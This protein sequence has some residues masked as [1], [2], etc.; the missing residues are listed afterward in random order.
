MMWLP[1]R[2]NCSN[3][4][5]KVVDPTISGTTASVRL[6]PSNLSVNWPSSMPAK[7]LAMASLPSGKTLTVKAPF[8]FTKSPMREF[9]FKHT[10]T[11]GGS[12]ETE[13]KAE[14]VAP[15]RPAAPSV[16]TTVTLWATARMAWMKSWRVT[17]FPFN[18]LNVPRSLAEYV[19]SMILKNELFRLFNSK[20]SNCRSCNSTNCAPS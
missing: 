6:I 9:A 8:S 1:D 13:Q 11:V 10:K 15:C 19:N 5:L 17:S 16:V 14:T 3:W 7:R 20:N 4:H 18:R 2:T 12:A